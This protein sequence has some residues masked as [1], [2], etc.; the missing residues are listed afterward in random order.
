M[1]VALRDWGEFRSSMVLM[2]CLVSGIINDEFTPLQKG[3]I[4]VYGGYRPLGFARFHPINR[5]LEW[6]IRIFG[7]VTVREFVQR[8]ARLLQTC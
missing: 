2:V 4:D 3:P 7:H 8:L 6:L 5:D 1:V